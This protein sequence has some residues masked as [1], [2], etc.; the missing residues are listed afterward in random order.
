MS[1]AGKAGVEEPVTTPDGQPPRGRARRS[2]AVEHLLGSDPAATVG[3]V[4]ARGGMGGVALFAL[5]AALNSDMEQL[6]RDITGVKSDITE[7]KS[8]VAGVREQ[9]SNLRNDVTRLQTQVEIAG[10]R[11]ASRQ[12][13]SP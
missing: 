9:V 1:P 5:W 7:V 12:K 8:D 3:A 4:V 10:Q 6:S 2:E 11:D 13:A